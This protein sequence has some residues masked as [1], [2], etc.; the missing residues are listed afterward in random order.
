MIHHLPCLTG[1]DGRGKQRAVVVAVVV[2]VVEVVVVVVVVAVARVVVVAVAVVV[3]A[4]PL[5][6]DALPPLISRPPCPSCASCGGHPHSTMPGRSPVCYV[7]YISYCILYIVYVGQTRKTG[8]ISGGVPP[9]LALAFPKY[10][11]GEPGP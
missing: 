1:T 6:A 3:A 9:A 4:N 2:V 11:D 10:P 7:L 8:G 5:I